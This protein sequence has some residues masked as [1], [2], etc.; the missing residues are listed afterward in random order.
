MLFMINHPIIHTQRNLNQSNR[1]LKKDNPRENL[2]R[3]LGLK[4]PHKEDG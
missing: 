4:Y 2:Y 1:E 3:Q